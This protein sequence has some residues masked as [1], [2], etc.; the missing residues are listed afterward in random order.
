V[1]RHDAGHGYVE[2]AV[3]GHVVAGGRVWFDED[4]TSGEVD[5]TLRS[6][7]AA[8]REEAYLRLASGERLKVRIDRTT[9]IRDDRGEPVATEGRYTFTVLRSDRTTQPDSTG[10]A[11]DATA[12]E[13]TG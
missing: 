7:R 2:D 13:N 12:R 4:R 3:T 11:S 1:P 9:A 8:C 6:D 5:D 10:Q